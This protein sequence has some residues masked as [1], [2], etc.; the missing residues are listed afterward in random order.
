MD[1][2]VHHC[3][4]YPLSK[5]FT[6]E[7]VC[8]QSRAGCEVSGQVSE[9]LAKQQSGDGYVLQSTVLAVPSPGYN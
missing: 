7:C 2:Y 9:A 6:S 5:K 3:F 1:M 4:Q 8:P